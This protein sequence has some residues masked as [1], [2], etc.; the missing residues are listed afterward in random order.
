MADRADS[1]KS[2]LTTVEKQPVGDEK[3]TEVG[4]KKGCVAGLCGAYAS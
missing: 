2:E 3:T 1:L 4:R